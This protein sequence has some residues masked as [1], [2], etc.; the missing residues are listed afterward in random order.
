MGLHMKERKTVR[1][2]GL[3]KWRKGV[4]ASAD[5]QGNMDPFQKS[6]SKGLHFLDAP[7]SDSQE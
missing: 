5:S 7:A 6:L 3:N 2:L 1:V 4:G